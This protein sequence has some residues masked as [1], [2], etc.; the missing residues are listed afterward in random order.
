MVMSKSTLAQ[1]KVEVAEIKAS[2]E[3]IKDLQQ[4][5]TTSRDNA[6]CPIDKYPLMLVEIMKHKAAF[7]R[8]LKIINKLKKEMERFQQK[9]MPPL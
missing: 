3:R 2:C 6:V 9:L 5:N 1:L 8:G 7:E 4:N